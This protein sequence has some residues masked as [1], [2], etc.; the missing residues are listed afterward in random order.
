MCLISDWPENGQ[1][2]TNMLVAKGIG[3]EWSQMEDLDKGNR[4]GWSASPKVIRWCWK[5]TRKV[6][7]AA[8]KDKQNAVTGGGDKYE[9]TAA[10][11]VIKIVHVWRLEEVMRLAGSGPK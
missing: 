8:R 11:K 7:L 1:K 10:S 5:M 4:S 6:V 3:S 2:G 9:L